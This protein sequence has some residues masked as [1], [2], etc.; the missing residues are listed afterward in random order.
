MIEGME[1]PCSLG[2]Y[3]HSVG[4]DRCIVEMRI[5]RKIPWL[6]MACK[7]LQ[8]QLL[9]LFSQCYFSLSVI[10]KSKTWKREDQDIDFRKNT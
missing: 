1:W 4:V 2:R 9:K 3:K 8:I 10:V 6:E 5:T 7:V